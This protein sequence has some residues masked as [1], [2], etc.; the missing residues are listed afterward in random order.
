[1]T[2]LN[3]TRRR[4]ELRCVAINGPLVSLFVY[5]TSVNG[6]TG[7]ETFESKLEQEMS[8][9]LPLN[10]VRA[11]DRLNMNEMSTWQLTV[12]MR[13]GQMFFT[14]PSFIRPRI[15]TMTMYIRRTFQL[16]AN[17]DRAFFCG[18]DSL[19]PDVTSSPSLPT[20]K[21]PLETAFTARRVCITQTMPWQDVCLSVRLSVTG[22]Y[23]V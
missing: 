22:R 3:T 19:P 1:M 10:R 17:G 14:R 4:V 18:A 20:S 13:Y 5:N 2:Q 16:S 9:R 6:F 12:I 15:S 23:S 21:C 11:L 8:R 7:G